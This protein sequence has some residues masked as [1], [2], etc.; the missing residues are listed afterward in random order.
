MG[1]HTIMYFYYFLSA[2]GP[3]VQKYLWWKKYLTSLQMVQFAAFTLHAAQPIFIDCGFP[4]VYCLVILGHGAMFLIMFANF[5]AQSY[6]QK[7]K[8]IKNTK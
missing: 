4:P 6:L 7:D 2:L 5:Y 8:K 1:I 3:Q